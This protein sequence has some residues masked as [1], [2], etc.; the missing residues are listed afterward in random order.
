MPAVRHI[1]PRRWNNLMR[2]IELHHAGRIGML[3]GSSSESWAG[4]P[5]RLFAA[6][7]LLVVHGMME[8]PWQEVEKVLIVLRLGLTA[9]HPGWH[10]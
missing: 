10:N 2:I 9:L 5:D 4:G 6:G 7:L 8:K 3:H 1:G